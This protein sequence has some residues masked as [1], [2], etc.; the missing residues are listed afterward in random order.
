MSDHDPP[1][2]APEPGPRIQVVRARSGRYLV[3]FN[4]FPTAAQL[5]RI[6]GIP[7]RRWDRG[8]KAWILPGDP[9]TARLLEEAFPGLAPSA[10]LPRVQPP[11]QP[12]AQSPGPRPSPAVPAATASGGSP[13]APG[14][15]GSPA[16]P[17]ARASRT[18]LVTPAPPPHWAPLLER[19]RE[20]LLL[21][22]YSPRTRKVYLGHIRRFLQWADRPE[23]AIDASVMR[24]WILHRLDQEQISRSSHGQIVS[25]LRI[26]LGRILERKEPP[27]R[28]PM[29]KRERSLP[30]V[31]SLA[32]VRMLLE[33]ARGT[34]T[35]ALLMLLY[36]SGMRVGE[37][38][39]LRPGDLEPAR[40]L[41]RVRKGKGAKDRYT[42][43]S[44]RALEAVDRYRISHRPERWLFPSRA[45]PDRPMTTRTAQKLVRMTAEQAGLGKRVT[46]HMLRHS[47]A[48]HLLEAGTDLRY[49]QTLLGH[50]STRTTEISTPV[51]RRELARIR[52]PLDDDRFGTL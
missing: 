32:E 1:R 5:T 52:S 37:V 7:G 44:N 47:F 50:A 22:G 43:L 35:Q 3:R 19:A 25:A 13:A 16:G 33:A 11:V 2:G 36:S 12:P 8:L 49:I 18:F 20:E 40:G 29:P 31:L 30:K 38:V 4:P 28:V 27:E 24:R 45:D 6:R 10:A 14:A 48:T 15:T 42:L 26:L 17:G 41:L 39:R 21:A 51:S 46:P 23:A 34:R 9:F